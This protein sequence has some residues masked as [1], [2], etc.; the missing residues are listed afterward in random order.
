MSSP[1][2]VFAAVSGALALILLL[3]MGGAAMLSALYPDD[4]NDHKDD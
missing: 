4:L 3:V 1:Y 2:I